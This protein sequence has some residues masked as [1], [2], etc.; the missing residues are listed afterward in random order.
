MLLQPILSIIIL[1]SVRKSLKKDGLLPKW[2][3][4][5]KVATTVFTAVLVLDISFGTRFSGIVWVAHA[6]CFG[7]VYMVYSHK[8]FNSAKSI[9]NA[10][11]PLIILNFIEDLVKVIDPSFYSHWENYFEAGGTFGFIWMVTMVIIINKQKKAL[12]KE[13]LKAEEKEKEYKITEAIKA[14]LEVQVNERTAE[15]TKQKEEL[16]HTLNELKATQSQ[17]IQSEKMASLGELTAGIAHEIQNPLNFINNFSELNSELI[18]E[19]NQ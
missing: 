1:S 6:L 4:A 9:T 13:Q 16:Q 3:E 10:F 7:L 14:E 15:L 19:M 8:D 18:E 11:L 2:N 12:E 5:V 17:L